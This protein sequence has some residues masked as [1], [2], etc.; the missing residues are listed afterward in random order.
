MRPKLGLSLV[1]LVDEHMAVAQ[2]L[3]QCDALRP[4][5]H[6]VDE[7]PKRVGLDGEEQRAHR[8][9]GAPQLLRRA[10]KPRTAG[11]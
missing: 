4:A 6:A 2:Q 7:A 10:R 3:A 11:A 5:E 9:V 1:N 8:L